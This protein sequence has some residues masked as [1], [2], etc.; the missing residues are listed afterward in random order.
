[1]DDDRIDV[2]TFAGPGGWDV[3]ATRLGMKRVVGFE[4]DK[5]ACATRAANGHHTVRCDVAAYDPSHLRGRVRLHISS[6]P[7]QDFSDA[8]KK[9]YLD[10]VRGQLVYQPMRWAELIRPESIALEQVP[11]VII[12]W[13][14]FADLLRDM[15]YKVWTGVLDA[16]EYGVPQQRERAILMAS[17]KDFNPPQPTHGDNHE[18]D[19]LFGSS[20]RPR[21]TMGEALGWRGTHTVLDSRGDG[22]DGPHSRSATFTTDRPARTLGEK[23]RSWA[24]TPVPEEVP[25]WVFRRPATTVVGSFRPD[26][27]A[28]PGYRKA[29]DGPRQNAPGSVPITV[30][31]AGV[32][33]SF[34]RDY[35]WMGSRT[36]QFEQVGNAIPP[37]LAEAI[38]KELI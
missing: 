20:L 26:I 6:P 1:M 32:L 7:C 29:G 3:A 34:P 11:K 22:G 23:A 9:L 14:Y 19:D 2:D 21:I 31:Q 37:L 10:G 16:S 33:Q 8:G 28:G 35:R 25:E 18:M 5:A 27:M 24:V 12:I 15:G 17:L 38:L 30:E 4:K 36:K 13:K